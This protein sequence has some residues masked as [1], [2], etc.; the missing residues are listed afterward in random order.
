MGFRL[1]VFLP[2]ANRLWIRDLS[3]PLRRN[4]DHLPTPHPVE[5]IPDLDSAPGG[6]DLFAVRRGRDRMGHLRLSLH[7]TTLFSPHGMIGTVDKA[8]FG[9]PS[10]SLSE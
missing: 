5:P 3:D 10:I 6:D 2:V 4:L 1:G 7:D 9:E 8:F